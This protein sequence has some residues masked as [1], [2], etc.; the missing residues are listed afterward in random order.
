M[1]VAARRVFRM[2]LTM[3]LAMAGAYAMAV[4]L[5]YLAPVFALLF[6]LKP[7][8]PMGLKSLVGLIILVGIT[9]GVG[10][11]MVPLLIHYP[12]LALL[13]VGAGLFLA[14]YL[15]IGMGKGAVGAFLTVGL[16]LISAAGVASFGVACE[17]AKALAIGIGMAVVCQWIVYPLFPEAA[18]PSRPPSKVPGDSGSAVWIA[19]RATVIVMPVYLV[20]LTNPS[21]YL[22]A[23][24][25]AVSLGQQASLT[26]ARRAGRELLGSTCMG[27]ACAIL[28]WFGLQLLPSL[29]MLFLWMAL[30][31]I[32]FASKLYRLS[33]SR[34]PPSF[35][36]NT[37]ITLLILLGPAIQD[38][39][40]GKDVYKAFAVRMSLFVVVT[41]YA[42]GAILVLEYVNRRRQCRRTLP[43]QVKEVHAC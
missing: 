16:T 33:T 20:A 18:A 14:N 15:T 4:P 29:W 32:Y 1:P 21:L 37:A 26:D 34:Y 36:V 38:S 24:M 35:W 9:M 7:A 39:A 25:K 40:N 2:G 30:F 12:A 43:L 17:V 27:G 10:L 5:P 19:A 28:F 3:A 42:W 6:T 41:L 13:I 8:P 22:A 23:I 11:V 31:G